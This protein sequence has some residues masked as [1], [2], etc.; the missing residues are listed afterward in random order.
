MRRN[1]RQNHRTGLDVDHIGEDEL[2]GHLIIVQK[3]VAPE[4]SRAAGH[5]HRDEEALVL[6][7]AG[8]R[9]RTKPLRRKRP[10]AARTALGMRL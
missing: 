8:D 4:R 9:P 1:T 3:A 10:C 5:C 6:P 7:S 2:E